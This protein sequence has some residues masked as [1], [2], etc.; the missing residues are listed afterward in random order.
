MQ[1]SPNVSVN[2]KWYKNR[3][4][5]AGLDWLLQYILGNSISETIDHIAVGNDKS[6]TNSAQNQLGNER[7][8]KELT[9]VFQDGDTAVFET[10]FTKDEANFHWR[11]IGLFRG[12][13]IEANS[14]TL[15]ARVTVNEDKTDTKT[16]T[17]TWEF[18]LSNP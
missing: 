2:G 12:G 5:N 15:I 9:A 10:F 14:G 13:T 6:P 4:V 8:R 3:V 1:I 11:E 7:F 16:A 17:V 18:R